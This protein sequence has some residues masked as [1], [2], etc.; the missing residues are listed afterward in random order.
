MAEI[1]LDFR[2]FLLA[3]SSVASVAGDRI[4]H[5]HVPQ[6]KVKP[7]VFYRRRNTE[8]IVCLDDSNGQTPDSY[9][10][11]VEAI[12]TNPDQAEELAGYIRSRCHLFRGALGE[13]TTKGV[14]V[15]DVSEDYVP[16]GTGGDV[17]LT[18]IAFDVEVHV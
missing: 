12:A 8:H 11:D 10:F 17:G 16:R 7:F 4:H 15:Q 18:V 6:G 14:F 5:N 2:T 3:D 1:A 13:T 9:A